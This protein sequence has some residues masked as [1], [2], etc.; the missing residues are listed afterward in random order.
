MI[1]TRT[2]LL[3]L[4]LFGL[5]TGLVGTRPAVAAEEARCN[6][7][8][9]EV[10]CS[11]STPRLILGD[12]FEAKVVAKNNGDTTL[13]N[14]TIRLRG[15][16][17]APCISGPGT[18]VSLLVE[19]L[20]PGESKELTARFQ[21]QSIGLARVLGSARDSLGWASGNCACTVEVIGLPAIHTDMSDKDLSGAEKGVFRIGE[22]FL[23]VLVV[24]NQQG[25]EATPDLKVVFTLPKELEFVSGEGEQGITV[26]GSGQGATTSGFVLAAP[27]GKVTITIRVKAIAAPASTLVKVV[28]STQTTGGVQLASDT[29]STTVQ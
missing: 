5:G 24:R 15:D 25:T 20:E 4:A 9:I 29:E 1:R 6:R 12:P 23:Y 11:T 28:A 8:N 22:E 2:W 7:W 10:S 19:K 16:Q 21:P 27:D 14:V 3:G 17:G 18:G 26:T 13:Q